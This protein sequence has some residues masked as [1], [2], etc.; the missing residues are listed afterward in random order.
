[1]AREGKKFISE[2]EGKSLDEIQDL[3]EEGKEIVGRTGIVPKGSPQAFAI[4]AMI[5]L[6]RGTKAGKWGRDQYPRGQNEDEEQ[7]A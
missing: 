5:R 4:A 7:A 6:E 1:M 3:A 2:F